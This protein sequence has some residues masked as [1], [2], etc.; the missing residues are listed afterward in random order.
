MKILS[1][2]DQWRDKRTWPRC[3]L[4]HGWLPALDGVNLAGGWAVGPGRVASNVLETRLGGCVPH[5]LDGW[6]CT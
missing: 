6:F 3:L 2:I 1:I 5:T 4:W